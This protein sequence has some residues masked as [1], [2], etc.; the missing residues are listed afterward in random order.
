L[1]VDNELYLVPLWHN[2]LYFDAKE[3]GD[4]IVLCKPNLPYNIS[5]D[6]NNNIIYKVSIKIDSE[7]CNMIKENG[8]VSCDIGEK[9]FRIPLSNLYM[10]ED[11][12]YKIKGRGIS[13]IQENDMYNVSCK[14]DIIIKIFLH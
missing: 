10:K 9:N 13:R 6:E 3:G 5:L 1:Y 11:Q 2:E 7:L 4:I 8:F 12:I 14:G